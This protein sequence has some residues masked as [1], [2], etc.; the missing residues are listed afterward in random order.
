MVVNTMFIWR[1]IQL[2][3]KKMTNE[4]AV[5]YMRVTDFARSCVL[6]LAPIQNIMKILY[7]AE[8]C[9][10]PCTLLCLTTF[11]EIVY[12]HCRCVAVYSCS[13]RKNKISYYTG[14]VVLLWFVFS[15][16]NMYN[17]RYEFKNA[18]KCPISTTVLLKVLCPTVVALTSLIM[19]FVFYK[20]LRDISHLREYLDLAVVERIED[21]SKVKDC[22]MKRCSS[23]SLPEPHSNET[24][25]PG[26]AVIDN[27]IVSV[28]RN[29]RSWVVML[30]VTFIWVLLA[31]LFEGEVWYWKNIVDILTPVNMVVLYLAMV[32][33]EKEWYRIFFVPC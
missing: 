11:L 28:N 30:L 7:R 25:T 12:V 10:L 17:A 2:Q 26:N 27:Y 18:S 6:I 16:G 14:C 15:V 9:D 3:K 20:P 29:V 23:K 31:K 1:R 8:L 4:K 22:N 21:P 24:L 13:Y 33:C 32:S 5:R 19:F